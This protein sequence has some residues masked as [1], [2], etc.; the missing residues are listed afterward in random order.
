[1]EAKMVEENCSILGS[2]S[3]QFISMSFAVMSRTIGVFFVERVSQVTG[4]IS[5]CRS[6][7]NVRL[8]TGTVITVNYE[9]IIILC[10]ESYYSQVDFLVNLPLGNKYDSV[11]IKLHITQLMVSQQILYTCVLPIN[12]QQ[13]PV[14]RSHTSTCAT[15]LY[16]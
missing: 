3:Q 8:L 15:A 2:F 4:L 16:I 12:P 7:I 5:L 6:W 10:T 13:L 9:T 1:V 14:Y 11:H